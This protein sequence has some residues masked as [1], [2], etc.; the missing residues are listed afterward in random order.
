MN[1]FNYTL[2]TIHFKNYNL[3]FMVYAGELDL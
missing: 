2:K 1:G 3:Y